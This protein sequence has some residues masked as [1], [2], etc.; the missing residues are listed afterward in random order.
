MVRAALT[1]A[2]WTC[3][4]APGSDHHAM[5]SLRQRRHME[6]SQKGAGPDLISAKWPW[7]LKSKWGEP[8]GS[9]AP[10]DRRSSTH[11]FD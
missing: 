8:T 7:S 5:I 11:C 4:D 3:P 9:I 2:R 10:L 6:W 1:R